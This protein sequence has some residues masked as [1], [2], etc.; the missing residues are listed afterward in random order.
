VI[1]NVNQR[2]VPIVFARAI[3][4]PPPAITRTQGNFSLD[5]LRNVFVSPNIQTGDGLFYDKD[6]KKWISQSVDLVITELDGG[7][8]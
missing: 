7:T 1:V 8:Y 2:R 5:S 6:L 4:Q 3:P